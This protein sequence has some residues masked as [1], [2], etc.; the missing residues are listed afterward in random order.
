MF[1]RF[2][3]DGAY[4]GVSFFFLCCFNLLPNPSFFGGASFFVVWAGQRS[5]QCLTTPFVLDNIAGHGEVVN[6]L[7]PLV[8]GV[9]F[10]VAVKFAAGHNRKMDT[11]GCE[12]RAFACEADVIPL[13][14]VPHAPVHSKETFHI[15]GMKNQRLTKQ[16][17]N[18]LT[19]NTNR[20]AAQAD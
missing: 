19:C 15:A 3:W 8:P 11:L 9:I 7:K 12:P 5:C 1:C 16:N 14:H 17:S 13:H 4:S 2:L 20:S 10:V 6:I 18:E